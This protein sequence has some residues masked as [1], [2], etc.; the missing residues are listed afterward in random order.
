M[1]PSPHSEP[2]G[3]Q[4]HDAPLGLL[5]EQSMVL[6]AVGRVFDPSV[7]STEHH[8]KTLLGN[9]RHHPT[10]LT[11]LPTTTTDE[12]LATTAV[13]MLA[14]AQ[15]LRLCTSGADP[16]SAVND[17]WDIDEP[18]IS[19]ED[20]TLWFRKRALEVSAC[21]D[22][23]AAQLGNSDSTLTIGE[24][25]FAAGYRTIR[26]A[27]RFVV[28]LR[29]AAW[30]VGRALPVDVQRDAAT[31]ARRLLCV[32]TSSILATDAYLSRR[33]PGL[34]I[35]VTG[36]IT[37]FTRSQIDEAIAERGGWPA[38]T[39]DRRTDFVVV[40][41]RSGAKKLAAAAEHLVPTIDE[42]AF[43]QLLATGSFWPAPQ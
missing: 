28:A 20:R 18:G 33:L 40:G 15:E 9:N 6:I 8:R 5:V 1:E 43:L 16:R 11:V 34:K 36:A 37:G 35:V 38:D 41:K 42:D 4:P 30:L 13:E 27:D 17:S 12:M 14:A 2:V 26:T 25:I 10:R 22:R 32:A 31:K 7:E 39:V 23:I 29:E 21:T 19:I 24:D 3:T